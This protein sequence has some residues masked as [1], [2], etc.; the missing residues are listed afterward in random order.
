[1]ASDQKNSAKGVVSKKNI[2]NSLHLLNLFLEENIKVIDSAATFL[3]NFYIFELDLDNICLFWLLGGL[4]S[5]LLRIYLSYVL[6]QYIW[7]ISWI[8]HIP[9]PCL[10][11]SSD[12]E[13]TPP[14]TMFLLS[15]GGVRVP[16]VAGVGDP[17]PTD[18]PAVHSKHPWRWGHSAAWLA[19]T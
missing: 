6:A 11:F 17:H 3:Q 10:F 5:I 7:L 4:T 14:P 9:K 18:S 1:M 19:L 15:S 8:H 12:T 16:P 2:F 13:K